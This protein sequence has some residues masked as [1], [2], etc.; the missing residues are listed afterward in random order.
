MLYKIV[1][2]LFLFSGIC[3]ADSRNIS[4]LQPNLQKL[5]YSLEAEAALLGYKIIPT[6][7]YRTQEEQNKLYAKGRT[8]PGKKVTWTKNSI[9]T[10]RR[11]FDIAIL[12][13]GK[14]TWEP[15]H[16]IRV[17]KLGKTLGLTWGGDWKVK[18]YCHFQLGEK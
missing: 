12:I 10:T 17:G 11:A 8:S 15:E 6:S 16:Y 13:D 2:I 9:H 18:D 5:Y 1:L 3:Y 7:T 14:I 4:D